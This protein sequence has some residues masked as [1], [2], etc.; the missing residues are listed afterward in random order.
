MD[1]YILRFASKL[2]CAPETISF[3]MCCQWEIANI[4]GY[5][6]RIFAYEDVLERCWHG[7]SG[8]M[9]GRLQNGPLH[10]AICLETRMCSQNNFFWNMLLMGE[11]KHI[12]LQMSDCCM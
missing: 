3:R 5:R 2:E 10:P 6:C 12:W 11:C 9:F 4:F 1:R 8:V 7:L